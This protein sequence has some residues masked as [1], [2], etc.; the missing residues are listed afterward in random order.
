MFN[1]YAK[2]NDTEIDQEV[3]KS[4]NVIQ[5]KSFT[6]FACHFSITPDIFP[7]EDLVHIFNSIVKNKKGFGRDNIKALTYN[8]YLEA[9]IK[10]CIFG[11]EKFGIAPNNNVKKEFD[12]IGL[13][14]DILDK[15][16][17]YLGLTPGERGNELAEI[18]K[19][20]KYEND[21][22]ILKDI[23]KNKLL[24]Q[25]SHEHNKQRR[26][27]RYVKTI[28]ESMT[29]NKLDAPSK[30]NDNE[31]LSNPLNREL[32]ENLEKT[33]EIKQINLD[34]NGAEKIDKFDMNLP[35][36]QID[37]KSVV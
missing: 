16:I 13:T 6:K 34:I 3:L 19:R 20:I 11:K 10:M 35:N 25:D 4:F 22:E 29:L 18:L 31:E 32:K 21:K 1:L 30:Y 24:P 2:L 5:Y 8:D 23:V 28:K 17:R 27:K 14:P 12:I 15:F 9:I 36:D 26:T 33:E 7:E 37:R